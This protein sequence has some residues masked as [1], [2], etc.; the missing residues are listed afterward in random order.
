[1]LTMTLLKNTITRN[2]SLKGCVS[3]TV[4]VL[5][6]DENEKFIIVLFFKKV[7]AF[8]AGAD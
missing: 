2:Q 7:V 8:T 5:K 1:M 6:F 3:S 4:L